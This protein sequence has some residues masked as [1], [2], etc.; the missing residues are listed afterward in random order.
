MLYTLFYT[1][2]YQSNDLY[3]KY[4]ERILDDEFSSKVPDVTKKATLNHINYAINLC[5]N[6]DAAMDVGSGNGHY[7]A[8]LASKFRHAVGV[9]VDVHAGQK[10][11]S[12]K[13]P[14]IEFFNGYIEK[15][16]TK[17]K[18][19]FVLLMDIFEHI[20]DIDPFMQQIAK[21]QD[22]GGIV[23]IVT[24]NPVF[25]GP[26]KES[27]MYY[28][29]SDYH[30]HIKHYTPNEVIDICKRVGYEPEFHVYEETEA[31]ARWYIFGRGIS[32]R[33]QR[34]SKL[35]IYRVVRPIVLVITRWTFAVIERLCFSVEKKAENDI[36]STRSS[37]IA[38][39][40]AR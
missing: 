20:P 8:A 28:K 14:N 26:A 13:Y 6:W 30:G 27:D 24:P 4:Q 38:F 33:D 10:E 40:K 2:M 31:R 11:L 23:Y 7:L 37:A 34:F 21:M 15:Y 22:I 5:D 35:A 9:E 12:A 17:H 32:R 25:C 16:S 29:K 1:K 39:K 19:C 3:K 18:F 36:F